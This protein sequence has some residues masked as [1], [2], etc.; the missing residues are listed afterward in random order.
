MPLL[1]CIYCYRVLGQIRFD[2]LMFS[3]SL[4]GRLAAETPQV[5]KKKKEKEKKMVVQRR[6]VVW[7]WMVPLPLAN[8]VLIPKVKTGNHRNEF[9][10]SGIKTRFWGGWRLE[11]RRRELVALVVQ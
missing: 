3:N 2:A 6:C 5:E 11:R 9:L 4:L 1:L 10:I 7:G 8:R